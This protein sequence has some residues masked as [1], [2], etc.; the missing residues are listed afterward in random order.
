MAAWARLDEMAAKLILAKE[1]R[2]SPE[3][4]RIDFYYWFYASMALSRMGGDVFRAWDKDLVETLVENQRLDTDPCSYRGSWDPISPWGPKGGRVYSTACCVLSLA[5]P[6][7][8]TRGD[9]DGPE[10]IQQLGQEGVR[11]ADA[12]RIL[13]TIAIHAIP[14]AADAIRR[15]LAHAEGEVRAA[16]FSALAVTDSSEAVLDTLATGLTDEDPNVVLVV[17]LGFGTRKQMPPSGVPRA[18]ALLG[19]SSVRIRRAAARALGYA[20]AAGSPA[21]DPLRTAL[22]DDDERTALACG[23]AILGLVPDDEGALDCVDRCPHEQ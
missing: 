14:G 7:R 10:L 5:A 15:F 17:L 9:V 3:E 22:D 23:R 13:K 16:A 12:R 2:W 8:I 4:G 11:P 20:G 1:P 21:L 6:G 19:S 18:V